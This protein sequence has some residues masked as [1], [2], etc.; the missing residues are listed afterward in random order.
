MKLD[1]STVK[2][3][4]KKFKELQNKIEKIKTAPEDFLRKTLLDI[5]KKGPGWI[6]TGV[7]QEY[8]ITTK[9][10]KSGKIGWVNVEAK[11]L[12]SVK[13]KYSGRR[14]T[15]THF[16]MRPA[17][18]PP[19]KKLDNTGGLK[20]P[21]DRIKFNGPAGKVAALTRGYEPYQ[22]SWKIKKG[23]PR[24]AKGKYNTPVFLAPLKNKEGEIT[25]Y[26]PFQ[27]SPNHQKKYPMDAIKT[28]SLPQMVTIGKDGPLHEKPA[29]VFHRKFEKAIDKNIEKAFRLMKK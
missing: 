18:P 9:E 25:K 20:V 28:V 22:V 26:I 24:K 16:D 13:F 19:L 7:A 27:R 23:K 21:G 29:K 4:W 3:E 6:A 10:I 12:D 8:N 1:N 11:D 5:E 17:T 15:P 2:I 14:L